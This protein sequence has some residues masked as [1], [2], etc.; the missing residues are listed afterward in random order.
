MKRK[1]ILA[2]ALICAVC[3]ISSVTCAAVA[4]EGIS[5]PATKA[6][7]QKTDNFNGWPT[8]G[9]YGWQ[10]AI[11]VAHV[12]DDM[13]VVDDSYQGN[14]NYVLY[15]SPT[16]SNDNKTGGTGYNATN[17]AEN[18]EISMDVYFNDGIYGNAQ[19][20]V[21]NLFGDNGWSN[22][23]FEK[24]Y[25]NDTNPDKANDSTRLTHNGNIIAA[26]YSTDLGGVGAISDGDG[27]GVDYGKW[28]KFALRKIDN[29][30]YI[31]LNDNPVCAYQSDSI[32]APTMTN[33]QFNILHGDNVGIF[34]D[35]ITRSSLT[36]LPVSELVITC[37]DIT[38]GQT[39]TPTA[40]ANMSQAQ[41]TYNY[42]ADN[43]GVKGV[44]LS[45][46]PVNAGTYWV[47]GSTP[48]TDTY[49]AATSQAV[50]FTIGKAA[51]SW[52]T[53]LTCADIEIGETIAPNAVAQHGTVTYKYSTSE[54]GEYTSTAPTAVGTYYVKAFV[55][56]LD[57][58]EDL[59]S[60]AVSFV[61]NE[62][63]NPDLPKSESTL[64]ITCPDI[65]YGQTLTPA[66][67]ANTSQAQVIYTYYADNDGVKG[68]ALSAVPVNAGTYWVQG[69]TAETETYLAATSQAVKFTIGKAANSW[70]TELTCA[71]VEAGGTLAPNAAAQHG[72]VTY[73]YSATQDGE[74]TSTAPTA[75][76]AYYVKAYVTGLDNYEDLAS[77]AV[78]FKIKAKP[79][80]TPTE[81][82]KHVDANND[83]KCDVCGTDMPLPENNSLKIALIATGSVVAA[84]AI[85]AVVIVLLKRRKK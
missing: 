64:V 13:E 82:D 84:G 72:T 49:A 5:M 42:F 3:L 54:D 44:A 32:V 59:V 14:I 68:D 34:A 41:V 67:T 53:E 40:T 6:A 20:Q 18:W 71:D 1:I 79:V 61:I 30:L 10:G 26:S 75:V 25:Y 12:N 81:C 62:S 19:F 31:C 35:N 7:V 22:I 55:T 9:G 36:V 74:Y 83:G 66:A 28:V 73:K 29:K 8:G 17:F 58:Y 11:A 48:Q 65:T 4:A 27:Y 77:D 56:G 80:V 47:Q 63:A 46:A 57:N 52:T 60:E 69:A 45:A 15:M 33:I 39:L 85:T 78:S 51:N 21:C 50:K 37:A 43:G 38:Y 23:I 24:G 16:T 2:F 70:T 76:G